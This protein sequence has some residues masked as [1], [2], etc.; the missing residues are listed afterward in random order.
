MQLV[1]NVSEIATV[2]FLPFLDYSYKE[3]NSIVEV[4]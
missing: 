4:G 2:L 3:T 1:Q